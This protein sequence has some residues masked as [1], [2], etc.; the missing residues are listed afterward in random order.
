MLQILGDLMRCKALTK[1]VDYLKYKSNVDDGVRPLSRDKSKSF[2]ISTDKF[3]EFKAPKNCRIAFVD[4][5]NQEII[6]T[7]KISI[8]FNRICFSIFK[9]KEHE[10]RNSK[11]PR[12][13]EFLS[14][15]CAELK[16]GEIHYETKLFPLKEEYKRFLPHDEHL[17][18]TSKKRATTFHDLSRVESISRRFAELSFSKYVLEKE[19]SKDDILVKDGSLQVTFSK[20]DKYLESCLDV[21]SKNNLYFLGISKTCRRITNSGVPL[22]RALQHCSKK[23][24]KKRWCYYPLEEYNLN[25]HKITVGAVKFS[26]ESR[27]FRFDIYSPKS[28]ILEILS[29][30]V[31]NTQDSFIHGYPYGLVKVDSEAR[32]RKNEVEIFKARLLQLI[33]KYGELKENI[34]AD[35]R[36][37]DMHDILDENSLLW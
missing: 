11:I 24:G 35:M 18:F 15:T 23:V 21:A 28:K 8:Q 14:V 22:I 32:V 20:E 4:G 37:V 31:P 7:P 34:L 5:G 25:N 19:L 6:G 2:E 26:P 16:N 13:I 9:G 33:H 27:I 12:K 17:S 29:A 36:A 10:K 3:H 30:I 1:L